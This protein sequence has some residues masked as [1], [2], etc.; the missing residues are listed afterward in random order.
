LSGLLIISTIP[1]DA[2]SEIKDWTVGLRL[3]LRY[4][5]LIRTKAELDG[6]LKELEKE[7]HVVHDLKEKTG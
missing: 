6:S 7:K 3:N 1:K 2:I 5:C 4:M